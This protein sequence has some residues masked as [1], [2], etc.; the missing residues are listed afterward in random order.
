MRLL[1][2]TVIVSSFLL[3]SGCRSV[4]ELFQFLFGDDSGVSDQI[5]M[6]MLPLSLSTDREG[7]VELKYRARV[8]FIDGFSTSVKL[9]EYPSVE[10]AVNILY[11]RVVGELPKPECGSSMK[12]YGHL[13]DPTRCMAAWG[14]Q[15]LKGLHDGTC[16]QSDVFVGQVQLQFY[17]D[18]SDRIYAVPSLLRLKDSKESNVLHNQKI[19]IDEIAFSS[20]NFYDSNKM[21]DIGSGVGIRVNKVLSDMF[22]QNQ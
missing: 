3:L 21:Y 2:R 10:S 14:T 17:S 12:E 20:E 6:I 18:E 4:S 15:T 5:C 19:R 1:F 7:E 13:S 11:Q 16:Q 22:T 8:N 9:G